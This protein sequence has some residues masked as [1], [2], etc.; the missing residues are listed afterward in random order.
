MSDAVFLL[1]FNFSGGAEPSCLAACDANLDGLVL[2]SA[3]DAIYLLQFTFLGGPVLPA[4][5]PGCGPGA[6]S[7]RKLGCVHGNRSCR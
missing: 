2:G 1:R 7:D 3:A 6:G 5:F 4:P